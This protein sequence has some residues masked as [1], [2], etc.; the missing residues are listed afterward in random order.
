MAHQAR[1]TSYGLLLVYYIATITNLRDNLSIFHN[2]YWVAPT[3]FIDTVSAILV[4][5]FILG[6][7]SHDLP[8]SNV[9][10]EFPS[11]VDQ[12]TWKSRL[13]FLNKI[14][15]IDFAGVLGGDLDHG[16]D[17][18]EDP[19]EQ[20]GSTETRNEPEGEISESIRSEAV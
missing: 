4:A 16:E 3:H 5:R 18:I 1:Y 8:K 15:S 19:D 11:L 7:R 10:G 9:P 14:K 2:D 20:S 13:V 17:D 12:S 6:L